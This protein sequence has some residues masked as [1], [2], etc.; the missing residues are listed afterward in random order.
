M[1]RIRPRF[2][3]IVILLLLTIFLLPLVSASPGTHTLTSSTGDVKLIAG[4]KVRID[5]RSQ[6]TVSHSSTIGKGK[7]ESWNI[8]LRGGT[9]DIS[10]YVPSPVSQWYSGSMSI[11]IGSYYDIPITTGI[12]ARVKIVSSASLDLTGDARLSTDSLSW[13]SEGTKTFE[14]TTYSYASGKITVESTFNFQI[15]LGLVIGISLFSIEIANTNV[16]TFTASPKVS[17]SMTISTPF[18]DQ[19]LGFIFSPLGFLTL[20]VA[21]LTIAIVISARRKGKK[22]ERRARR[23][24]A[25]ERVKKLIPKPL[26]RPETPETIRETPKQKKTVLKTEEVTYCIYCGEKLPSY[27]VYCRK[28]GKKAE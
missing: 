2:E 4:V 10:V 18:L 17:E 14:V 27:A 26:E 21:F 24:S 11:Q 19:I 6:A 7:T 22:R 25:T 13:S 9:I 20:L 28:C 8:E 16:G 15:N 5:Y 23:I 3:M 12:S 1:V